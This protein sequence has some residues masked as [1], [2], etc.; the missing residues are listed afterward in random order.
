MSDAN[1]PMEHHQKLFPEA[2]K[3][4]TKLDGLTVIGCK[5]KEATRHVHWCGKNPSFA[6]HLRTWGEAGPVAV[7]TD[8]TPK[9]ND[10][11]ITCMVIGHADDHAGDVCRMWNP[12]TN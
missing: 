8:M 12:K 5:G 4:A 2:A 10:R 6:N 7:K 11:G 3:T 9:V 1:V